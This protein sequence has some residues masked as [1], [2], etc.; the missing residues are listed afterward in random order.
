MTQAV[1]PI[2][3]FKSRLPSAGR[4]RTG[5]TTGRAMRALDTFRFT[6]A[7]KDLIE[8]L[9]ELYGGTP[10]PW[11]PPRGASEWEVITTSDVIQVVVPPH[12]LGNTPIYECWTKAGLQRRCDGVTMQTT[13]MSPD[14][15]IQVEQPCLCETA[16]RMECKPITRLELLLPDIPFT[17]TWMLESKGWTAAHEMPGMVEMVV[18]V[19][20]AGYARAELALEPE[21]VVKGGQT[22][23]FIVPR[24]RIPH[25]LLELAE[26]MARLGSLGPAVHALGN[27]AI[28]ELEA[29][30]LDD[31]VVEGEIVEAD[32]ATT[33]VA[34]DTD[35]AAMLRT[36][37]AELH[38]TT[39]DLM[40]FCFQVSKGRTDSWRDITEHEVAR[41][42]AAFAKILAGDL[43]Y[44][45]LDGRRAKVV[46]PKKVPDAESAD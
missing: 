11:Q 2:A 18:S 19:Q 9:A 14:G 42:R 1:R 28:A 22:R 10:Q 25:T 5:V 23:N 34:T 24:L 8:K 46:D 32:P 20:R 4:I 44:V 43:V 29:G 45:G 13:S 12:A 27:G 38:L 3:S 37:E 39:D 21:T 40:G 26:G 15:A 16:K 41:L 6:S 31:E 17:G 35:R 30:S 33:T 7:N 36:A